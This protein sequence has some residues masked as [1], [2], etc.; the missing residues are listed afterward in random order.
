VYNIHEFHEREVK[1]PGKGFIALAED[2]QSLVNAA[3]TILTFQGHPEMSAE[4]SRLLLGDTPQ[5]MSV[6]AAEKEAL[7][8]RINS[9][10]DGSAIWKRIIQWAGEV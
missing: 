7:E 8:I 4:L 6:D 2:N 9:P 3:N 5:Y 1:T 10:H